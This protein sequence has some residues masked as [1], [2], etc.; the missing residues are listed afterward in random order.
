MNL[1]SL[2][3]VI[4]RALI[5]VAG[6][7]SSAAHVVASADEAYPARPVKVVVGY[8]PGGSTDTVARLLATSLQQQHNQ[9]FIVDNRPGAGGLLGAQAVVNAAPD[10]YTLLMAIS[11]HTILPSVQKKMPYDTATDFAPIATLG[12]S[13]NMLVVPADSEWKSLADFI[14]AAKASPGTISYATP[15]IGTTTHVTA[16]MLE[17]ASG[18][19]LNH[20]PYKGSSEVMQAVLSK[21]V[22]IAVASIIT[23]G[24][25]IRDGRLRALAVVGSQRSPLL[26][27]VPTFEEQGVEGVLGDNWLGLL[28]PAHTPQPIVAELEDT[29]ESLLAKPEIQD[30]LRLQGVAPQFGTSEDFGNVIA[31]EL[32]AYAELAKTTTLTMD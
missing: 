21:Q 12:T 17:H 18:I 29:I 28:A 9:A 30:S 19:E 11:S 14:A 8:T 27:D 2:R 24:H 16:A 32:K 3:S 20:I 15:G 25:A 6:V 4:A 31:N 5:L 26:P 13:P 10:G 22:P 1:A 23:A 7:S